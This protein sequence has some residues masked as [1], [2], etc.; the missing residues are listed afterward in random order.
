MANGEES[1][2]FRRADFERDLGF[3]ADEGAAGIVGGRASG[4][5]FAGTGGG[6]EGG[7]GSRDGR[8]RGRSLISGDG[9]Q[10]WPGCGRKESCMSY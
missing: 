2:I 8:V 4:D 6:G 10:L 7:C 3:G 5:G 9:S 1:L